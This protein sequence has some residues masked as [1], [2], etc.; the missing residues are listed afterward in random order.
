MQIRSKNKLRGTT[1]IVPGNWAT[2]SS[3]LCLFWLS[4]LLAAGMP[5]IAAADDSIATT[6]PG[7]GE[8]AMAAALVS[9]PK[10]VQWPSGAFTDT[11]SPV[12]FKILGPNALV[13]EFEAL[14]AG[15]RING[16]P[17]ILESGQTG[18]PIL[19]H[20]HVV[21]VSASER[22]RFPDILRIAAVAKV[23]TVGDGD[24]FLEQGGVVRLVSQDRKIGIEVNLSAAEAAGLKISSRL[25]GVSRVRKEPSR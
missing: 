18:A 7:T 3:L 13:R 5:G 1:G 6:V 17:L 23:L 12:V 2:V 24:D 15:R 14:T 25:L 9:L 10:Y 19:E 11:N 4:A 8:E 20:C 22:R 16:R 21:F